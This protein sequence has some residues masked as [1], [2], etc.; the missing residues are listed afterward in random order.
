[1]LY[2]SV[3]CIMLLQVHGDVWASLCLP[4]QLLGHPA[5]CCISAF[6]SVRASSAALHACPAGN[7]ALAI[8]SR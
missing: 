7:W 5:S 6:L 3:L 2:L 4:T 8:L 1:M